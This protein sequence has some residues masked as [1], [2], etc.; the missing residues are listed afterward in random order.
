MAVLPVQAI[1]IAGVTP[2]YVAASAGGDQVPPGDKTHLHVKNGS[3]ASVNVTLTPPGNTRWGQPNPAIV[4]PVAA[5]AE[6]L[7]GP[8]DQTLADPATGNVGIAYS[9]AASVTVQARRI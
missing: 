1:S 6:L 4:V 9:A 5:G 8:L 7:I 2:A 3:A